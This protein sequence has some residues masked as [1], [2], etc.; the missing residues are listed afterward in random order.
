[1]SVRA[2][3]YHWLLMRM[4]TRQSSIVSVAVAMP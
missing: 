4:S 1:M 3:A 2:I